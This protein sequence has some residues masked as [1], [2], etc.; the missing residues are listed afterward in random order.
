MK[1]IIFI[2]FLAS[3]SALAETNPPVD[4]DGV[5]KDICDVRTDTDDTQNPEEG[6]LR[7]RLEL[8]NTGIDENGKCLLGIY[9]LESMTIK[10]ESPIFIKP[11]ETETENLWVGTYISGADSN[12]KAL[13]VTIDARAVTHKKKCAFIIEGGLLTF[14]QIHDLTLFV[15]DEEKAICDEEGNDLLNEKIPNHSSR[16]CKTGTLAK[17]CDFKDVDIEVDDFYIPV[18]PQNLDAKV[19]NWKPINEEETQSN[20]EETE[21]EKPDYSHIDWS[22]NDFLKEPIPEKNKEEEPEV[23]PKE[24]DPTQDPMVNSFSNPTCSFKIF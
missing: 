18:T 17:D 23:D 21:D 1:K 15:T 8:F 2:L 22:K 7:H 9:F 13:P 12:G 10:L 14:Q 20:P 4:D 16:E 11:V 5:T 24:E 3:F 19:Q 6:S